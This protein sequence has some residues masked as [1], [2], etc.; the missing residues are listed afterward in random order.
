MHNVT[1]AVYTVAATALAPN[2]ALAGRNASSAGE[3]DW[4]Q[5]EIEFYYPFHPVSGDV[6]R[7]G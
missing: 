4:R 5:R 7:D 3:T 2:E 6:S 1:P